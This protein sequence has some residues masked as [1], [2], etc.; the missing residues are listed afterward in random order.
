MLMTQRATTSSSP[1]LL[2]AALALLALGATL[3]RARAARRT[4]ELDQQIATLR[5]SASAHAERADRLDHDFRTPIGTA[6]AALEVLRTA[7]DDLTMQTEAC[8]VISRQL[9]R[10]TGLTE[11]LREIARGLGR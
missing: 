8:N 6:A 1:I 5:H 2:A 9:A 7:K 11:E 4:R 10:M 3:G